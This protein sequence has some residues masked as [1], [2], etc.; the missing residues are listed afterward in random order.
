MC[1]SKWHSAETFAIMN[2]KLDLIM[3]HKVTDKVK[4][5][6]MIMSVFPG[7]LSHKSCRTRLNTLKI[8]CLGPVALRQC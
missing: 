3:D 7:V 1:V 8:A 4:T 5:G 6:L 2:P